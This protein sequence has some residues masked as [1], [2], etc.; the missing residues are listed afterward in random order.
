MPHKI[1]SFLKW[2]WS[3]LRFRIT[4]NEKHRCSFVPSSYNVTLL[5]S[6][7][8]NGTKSIHLSLWTLIYFTRQT[9]LWNSPPYNLEL[10]QKSTTKSFKYIPA[11]LFI[12]LFFSKEYINR[13]KKYFSYFFNPRYYYTSYRNNFEF[14]FILM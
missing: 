7:L 4:W 11:Y 12:Y 8:R 1:A 3:R 5:F 14:Y 10:S 13:L 6:F 2:N 9:R